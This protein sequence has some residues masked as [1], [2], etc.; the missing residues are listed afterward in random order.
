MRGASG[1]FADELA[2][3]DGGL[4]AVDLGAAA[5]WVDAPAAAARVAAARAPDGPAVLI[6]PVAIVGLLFLVATVVTVDDDGAAAAPPARAAYP[7]LRD[8]VGADA[9]RQTS[10]FVR[11][12]AKNLIADSGA[13]LTQFALLPR[14]KAIAPPSAKIVETAARTEP[15]LLN[16]SLK[17]LKTS[18]HR[19]DAISGVST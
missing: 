10:S 12:Y 3:A 2:A 1:F 7:R 18:A 11:S 6:A 14:K 4:A 19:F 9:S 16:R 5:D 15:P 17:R 8:W 13:I